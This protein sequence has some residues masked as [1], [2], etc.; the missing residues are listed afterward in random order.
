MACVDF[1][2]S[3]HAPCIN[4][5]IESDGVG[6]TVA[7]VQQWHALKSLLHLFHA[8]CINLS[9]ES[10][11]VGCTVECVQ[12]WHAFNMVCVI[13]YIILSPPLNTVNHLP[14]GILSTFSVSAFTTSAHYKDSIT[15]KPRQN[16]IRRNVILYCSGFSILT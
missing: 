10:D 6:C 9:I 16:I 7:C 2:F 12:Q 8:P 14:V 1:M 15:P 3:F 13:L 4:L 11:S 5:S